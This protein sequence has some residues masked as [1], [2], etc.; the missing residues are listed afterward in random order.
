MAC[1]DLAVALE[2]SSHRKAAA[3]SVDVT[4][5]PNDTCAFVNPDRRCTGFTRSTLPRRTRR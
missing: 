3:G 2:C 1:W 4:Q 5:E